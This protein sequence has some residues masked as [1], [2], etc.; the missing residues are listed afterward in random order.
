MITVENVLSELEKDNVIVQSYVYSEK[1]AKYWKL[2]KDV[3][4]ELSNKTVLTIPKG[5]V[6]D[7]ATVPKWLWSFVRPFNDGLFGTLIHDYL[8]VNRIGTRRQAD[9]E[10]LFW[11]NLTNKNKFDNYIR[12]YTVRAF[13]WILWYG[14]LKTKH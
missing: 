3:V 7:M 12:Y 10:Y 11:N 2:E 4:V 13:G 8:Y 1:S 5:Y 14:V 9:R 6:Y